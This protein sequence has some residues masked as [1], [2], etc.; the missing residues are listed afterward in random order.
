[1]WQATTNLGFNALLSFNSSFT[2]ALFY[3]ENL[4]R[5]KKKKHVKEEE[6]WMGQFK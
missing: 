2:I 3:F 1:M 4:G 6:G 5:K